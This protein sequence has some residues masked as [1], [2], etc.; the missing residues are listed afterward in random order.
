VEPLYQSVYIDDLGAEPQRNEYG[1]FVDVVG[2]FIAKWY[3]YLT[4]KPSPRRMFITT[5]LNAEE[6]DERYGGRVL[7]RLK[8]IVIPL[9]LKGKDKR[10]WDL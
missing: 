10:K 6:I 8:D 2:D 7:S 9:K 5:N 3:E 4:Y 1:V